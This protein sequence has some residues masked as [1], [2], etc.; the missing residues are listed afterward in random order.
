MTGADLE[1]RSEPVSA[2]VFSSQDAVRLASFL[3]NS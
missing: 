1:L 2:V 3:R